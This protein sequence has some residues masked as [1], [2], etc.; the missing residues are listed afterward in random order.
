MKR[1]SRT[2]TGKQS[3][4][5]HVD[6]RARRL[7]GRDPRQTHFDFYLA[8][9]ALLDRKPCERQDLEREDQK[10]DHLAKVVA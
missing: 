5:T 8:M 2:D 7:A 9:T 6:D 1:Q 3:R 10:L 4:S